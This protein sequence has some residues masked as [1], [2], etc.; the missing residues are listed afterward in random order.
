[1]DSMMAG[2]DNSFCTTCKDNF[3]VNKS[4]MSCNFCQ[5]RFHAHCLK[6]K[7]SLCKSVNESVNMH[8]Y[9]D[10]C[11]PVVVEKLTSNLPSLTS[12]RLLESIDIAVENVVSSK[13]EELITRQETSRVRMEEQLNEMKTEVVLLKETNVDMLRLYASGNLP[14]ATSSRQVVDL[15]PPES[16]P[17]VSV[18]SPEPQ[19]SMDVRPGSLAVHFQKNLATVSGGDSSAGR[20][21]TVQPSSFH[22]TSRPRQ[23]KASPSNGIVNGSVDPPTRGAGGSSDLL[24]PAPKGRKWIW[25]GN[26]A[27]TST[28]EMV[29]RHVLASF[30]GKDVLAFDLKSR[31][32]RKSFKVGSTD[33]SVED[34]QS[35]LLWPDGILI[36]PFRVLQR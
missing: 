15:C 7:D 23:R 13:L 6:F 12:Q 30:P 27:R 3:I 32:A 5:R 31:S 16:H 35:P 21:K 19:P 26:L 29:V 17:A 34:L 1:M 9:C 4:F 14:F 2:T 11:L 10:M 36:R 24:K 20:D 18:S 33:I 22:S 28:A 8:W 25:I